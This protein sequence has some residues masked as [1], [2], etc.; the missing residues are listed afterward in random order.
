MS[1]SPYRVIDSPSSNTTTRRLSATANHPLLQARPLTFSL[2]S[3]SATS[4]QV[5]SSHTTTLF[6][7]YNGL[8]P[9]PIKNSREAVCSGITADSVP[10]VNSRTLLVF[11]WFK[12]LQA[13][14]VSAAVSVAMSDKQRT[15]QGSRK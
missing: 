7:G 5:A 8:L 9:P 4:L 12:A 3:N 1:H 15:Q 14:P 6:G 10:P 2:N 11:V 13:H